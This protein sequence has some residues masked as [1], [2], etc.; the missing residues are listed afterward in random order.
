GEKL[1]RRREIAA[2]LRGA[3]RFPRRSESHRDEGAKE[4]AR[5]AVSVGE[6]DGGRSGMAE[7]ADRSE[8]RK[9][10]GAVTP[11]KERRS[12]ADP[13]RGLS[14]RRP[15]NAHSARRAVDDPSLRRVEAREVG[16]GVDAEESGW[17]TGESRALGSA[18]RRRHNGAGG[19][20]IGERD[21]GRTSL[22]RRAYGGCTARGLF[23]GWEVA[24]FGRRRQKSDRLGLLPA[25]DVQ[26]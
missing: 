26:E 25:R 14:R 11:R 3:P 13:V 1:K 2:G 20:D 18:D 15:E 16:A 5:R 17:W 21:L 8:K 19:V 6:R 10:R 23:A 4:E 12:I 9:G 24:G 22:A 7:I